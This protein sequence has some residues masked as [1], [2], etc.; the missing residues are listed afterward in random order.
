MPSVN[1]RNAQ[2]CWY[3]IHCP[4]YCTR[5]IP[6]VDFGTWT[7]WVRGEQM[8]TLKLLSIAAAIIHQ[9]YERTRSSP[10]QKPDT[11]FTSATSITILSH[12]H[13]RLNSWTKVPPSQP[14]RTILFPNDAFVVETKLAMFSPESS[15]FN[16]HYFYFI[17]FFFLEWRGNAVLVTSLRG[18]NDVN[19]L[20]L[21]RKLTIFV[22]QRRK[23]VLFF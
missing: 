1:R 7:G 8:E 6:D 21:W 5:R 19:F 18:L 3:I 17:L 4:E 12:F 23:N 14:A 11:E 16:F 2:L 9:N 13:C 10:S 20:L 22:L 15:Q